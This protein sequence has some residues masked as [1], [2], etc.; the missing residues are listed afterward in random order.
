MQLFQLVQARCLSCS[1]ERLWQY[2]VGTIPCIIVDSD[3]RFPKFLKVLPV[4]SDLLS[5]PGKLNTLIPRLHFPSE[6]FTLKTPILKLHLPVARSRNFYAWYSRHLRILGCFVVKSS[7]TLSEKQL[8][9]CLCHCQSHLPQEPKAPNSLSI[10]HFSIL[11]SDN[12]N[13]YN[14]SPLTPHAGKR[15]WAQTTSAH[16]LPH[17]FEP[18]GLHSGV[19]RT[20]RLAALIS[21]L[22]A[23][24]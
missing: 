9:S 1:A 22:S 7:P 20:G 18:S 16:F 5:P 24:T 11:L 3:F 6:I 12:S 17:F 13:L 19:L 2:C 4:L 10:N 21:Q 15:L 14:N 8:S 23:I